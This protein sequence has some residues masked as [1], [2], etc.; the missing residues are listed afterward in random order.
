M[1]E[2]IVKVPEVWFQSIRVEADSTSDAIAKVENGKGEYMDNELSYSHTVGP[3]EGG[4]ERW[5]VEE[6]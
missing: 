1:S 3:Y 2:F 4:Y 5:T 6:D